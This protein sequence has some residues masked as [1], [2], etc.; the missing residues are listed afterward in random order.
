MLA[1]ADSLAIAL[2]GLSYAATLQAAGTPMFLC[3]YGASLDRSAAVVRRIGIVTAAT[4]LVLCL[5]HALVEPARLTGELSGIFDLSLQRLLLA[6]P[7][8]TATAVRLLGLALVLI[9]LRRRGRTGPTTAL[10][11]A[12]IAAI[13]FAL[14][15]HTAA[16]S[17]R[18]L[19]AP[20]LLAHVAVAA[21]WLGSLWPLR[22]IAGREP[23]ELAGQLIQAFS[24]TAG[25]LVP[26]IPIAGIAMASLLLPGWSSLRSPYGFALG[27]KLAGLTLLLGLAAANKWRFGPRIGRGDRQAAVAFRRGV[28]AE[29]LLIL[30]VVIVTALMTASF[31]PDH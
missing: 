2:R 12:A 14:M 9:G 26:L 10:V 1:W 28:S 15:G 23:H 4:A 31:S 24:R 22:A 29:W 20:L 25:W 11:G 30:L 19:L 6:S 21:F 7:A 8:G 27:A 16:D 13:S 5:T 3:L 17:Q 18:W